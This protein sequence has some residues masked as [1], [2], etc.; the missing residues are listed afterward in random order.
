M[1]KLKKTNQFKNY[2]LPLDQVDYTYIRYI[3]LNVSQSSNGH[4]EKVLAPAAVVIASP[5]I[6]CNVILSVHLGWQNLE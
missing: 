4:A 5:G 2:I 6:A 3:E 1:K